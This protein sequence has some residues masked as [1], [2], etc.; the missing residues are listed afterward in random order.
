M[1][2]YI[3]LILKLKIQKIYLDNAPIYIFKNYIDDD[4]EKI[5]RIDSLYIGVIIILFFEG[6]KNNNLFIGNIEKLKI[7]FI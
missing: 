2:F 4:S 6:E 5:L 1:D 7:L 3:K